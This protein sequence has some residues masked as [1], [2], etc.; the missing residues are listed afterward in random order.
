ML[1]NRRR[2]TNVQHIIWCWIFVVGAL[3]L[4]LGFPYRDDYS[5]SGPDPGVRRVSLLS[6]GMD[7]AADAYTVFMAFLIAVGVGS[8]MTLGGFN[9]W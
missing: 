5:E 4:V 6:N 8:L 9:R 1:S 3:F 7:Q 2:A